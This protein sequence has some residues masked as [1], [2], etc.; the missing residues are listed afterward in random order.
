MNNK[1]ILGI[2]LVIIGSLGIVILL[3]LQI[4]STSNYGYSP[5][6]DSTPWQGMMGQDRMQPYYTTPY[7][8]EPLTFDQAEYLAKQFLNSLGNPDLAIKEIMEFEYNFYIIYYEKST[9]IG[10]FE[11]LIWKKTSADMMGQGMMVGQLMPEPGPNMMWNT[12]Y[13]SMMGQ[14]GSMMNGG[15]MGGG[16]MGGGMMDGGILW[17]QQPS[18]EML[19]DEDHPKSIVQQYLD[20]YFPG[21]TVIESTPL[22]GYYTFDFGMNDK[23]QGMLS[24]NGHTGQVWYHGWHGDFIQMK[25]FHD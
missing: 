18:G 14:F 24:V 7:T 12:K 19:I 16:M 5:M 15:M 4:M 9:G 10:A 8:S 23:I 20:E 21:T 22:Y 13:G 1:Q 11:M 3:P 6:T 17:Q 2:A 25:E